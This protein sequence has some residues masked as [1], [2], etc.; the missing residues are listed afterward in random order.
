VINQPIVMAEFLACMGILSWDSVA[1]KAVE[2]YVL[3]KMP[4][5]NRA[6]V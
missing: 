5:G 2:T 3:H 6:T 1:A 4:V